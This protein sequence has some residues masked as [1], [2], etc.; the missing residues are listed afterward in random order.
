LKNDWFGKDEK[1]IV[2]NVDLYK[3]K[4]NLGRLEKRLGKSNHPFLQG[5]RKRIQLLEKKLEVK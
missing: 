1:K 5:L 3:L 4:K 2:I